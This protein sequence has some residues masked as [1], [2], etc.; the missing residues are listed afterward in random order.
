MSLSRTPERG[1]GSN[2]FQDEGSTDETKEGND[3]IKTDKSGEPSVSKGNQNDNIDNKFACALA[4]SSLLQQF[5]NVKVRADFLRGKFTMNPNP[6]LLPMIDQLRCILQ[7]RWL[8]GGFNANLPRNIEATKH[9]SLLYAKSSEIFYLPSGSNSQLTYDEWVSTLEMIARD[10][11]WQNTP[12][13]QRCTHLFGDNEEFIPDAAPVPKSKRVQPKYSKVMTKRENTNIEEVVISSDSS[14]STTSEGG[15]SSD[16]CRDTTD[17]SICSADNS[18]NGRLS[19]SK[20]KSRKRSVVTP[21]VF[22]MD[23]KTSLTEFLNT[24]ETYFDKQYS[25][26]S[27]DKTQMLAKFLKGEL[28]KMYEIRGG[29]KLKYRYMKA[30]L[31]K[32]YKDQKIGSRTYW[33]KQLVEMSLDP[34]EPYDLFGMRLSE[35]ARMAY[36]SDKK[37]AATQLRKAFLKCLPQY[38]LTKVMDAERA[39]NASTGTKKHLPFKAIATMAKDLQKSAVK[40]KTVLFASSLNEPESSESMKPVSSR[41]YVNANQTNTS[42]VARKGQNNNGQNTNGQNG[43]KHRNRYDNR[44]QN[45]YVR[46]GQKNQS[47]PKFRQGR[48]DS[49]D[50]QCFHCQRYGHKKSDCWRVS[51]RCLICGGPHKIEDCHRYDPDYRSKSRSRTTTDQPL[52]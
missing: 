45:N 51:G 32:Y 8:C 9:Y 46:E 24:Y 2:R 28:L 1:H 43:N 39:H 48:S 21:P 30:E 40:P 42:P 36:P 44:G 33:K 34:E 15:S 26:N 19:R 22:Q 23:G 16:S 50:I 10:R 17:A 27:Y 18:R 12:P 31:L 6:D 38:T 35:A 25:G 49:R 4:L 37:E 29:R 3:E 7:P 20:R 5:A 14:D 11:Y 13:G 41:T 52:N 47:P